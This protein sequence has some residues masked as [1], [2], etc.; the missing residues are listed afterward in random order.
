MARLAELEKVEVNLP[1]DALLLLKSTKLY[2]MNIEQKIR[3]SIAIDLFT[4]GNVSMAK[5]S[6][7][8]GIHRY[9]FMV[10]LNNRGIPVYEYTEKEYQEDQEAI[11]KYE[12]LKNKSS[13]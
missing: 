13:I 12:E 6:E 8:A 1:R 10:L 3:L 5:A 4:A 11:S 2:R 9:D 7:I